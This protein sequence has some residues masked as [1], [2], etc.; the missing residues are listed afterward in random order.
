MRSVRRTNASVFM[1]VVADGPIISSHVRGKKKEMVSVLLVF[2]ERRQAGAED[3]NM[4]TKEADD[5]GAIK[6]WCVGS[7]LDVKEGPHE[8]LMT[9]IFP[10][11]FEYVPNY[12]EKD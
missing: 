11:R 8:L 2:S 9:C 4:G 6:G 10:L 3:E 5:Y 7:M 12:R 1:Y